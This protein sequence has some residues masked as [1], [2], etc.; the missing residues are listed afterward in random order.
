MAH[1]S[2]TC[3]RL[4]CIHLFLDQNGVLIVHQTNQLCFYFKKKKKDVTHA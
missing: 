4:F 2:M 3:A 1:V